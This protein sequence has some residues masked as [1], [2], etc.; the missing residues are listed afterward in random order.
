M[1]ATGALRRSEDDTPLH[2]D[3][4]GEAKDT[5]EWIAGHLKISPGEVVARALGILYFLILEEE[6]KRRAVTENMNGGER[7]QLQI[8]GVEN[9]GESARGG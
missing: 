3:L 7:R 5:A 9:A 4:Y 6:K 1:A 2:V 8:M